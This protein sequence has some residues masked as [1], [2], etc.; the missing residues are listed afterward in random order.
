MELLRPSFKKYGRNFVFDPYGLYSFSTIEVGNDVYV[1]PGATLTATNSII[2]MGNK[3]MLGPNVSIIGG[4][5]NT[6]V[7][8]RFMCDI[9]EK[10]LED[11]QPV[12]IEDDVWIGTNVTIL[13][14][15]TIGTGS[16][17]AAGAVVT[18]SQPPYSII[19][20]IPAKVIKNRF[21]KED[22][23]NHLSLL[24]G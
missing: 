3:I 19:G 11:D 5:H 9:K 16:I 10:R 2:I 17:V 12:I 21:S 1:G 18:K 6:S 4:N 15:V 8:G 23:Q 7:I 20:G 22:L 13:K 24:Y 14:G